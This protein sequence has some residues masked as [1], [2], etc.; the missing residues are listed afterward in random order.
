MKKALQ[1]IAALLVA[2][3]FIGTF[4]FLYFNSRPKP[5]RYETLESSRQDI[6][7]STG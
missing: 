5:K 3:V 6:V 7:R 2:A 1:L 4:V